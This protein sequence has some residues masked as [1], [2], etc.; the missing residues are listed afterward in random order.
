SGFQ[1]E[2]KPINKVFMGRIPEMH[3]SRLLNLRGMWRGMLLLLCLGAAAHLAAQDTNANDNTTS[4]GANRGDRGQRFQ[5]MD[6]DNDG[7]VSKSE[8]KGS[9][10][11]FDEMDANKD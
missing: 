4:G 8:W 7:K 5:R 6:T 3:T 2:I 9:A 10:D 11:H 1:T